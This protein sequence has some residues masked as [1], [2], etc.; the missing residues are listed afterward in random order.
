MINILKR[1]WLEIDLSKL[2]KNLEIL[3]SLLLPENKHQIACVIKANAY[4]HDDKSIACHLEK[5]GVVFFAVSNIKEAIN[6]RKYGIKGEILILGYTPSEY[7]DVL[8][9]NN[10]IQTIVSES[11][12]IS[13]AECAQKKGIRVKVHVAL[14]TGMGR[15]GLDVI[16]EN[17]CEKVAKVLLN[18]SRMKGIE[19]DGLFTHYAVADSEDISDIE[20]T[21]KQTRLFLDVCNKV[22]KYGVLL[23]HTHCLNSAGGIYH[24]S[25]YSTLVRFGILLYGLKP[26]RN[27]IIPDGIEPIM[28]FKSVVSCVKQHKKGEFIGYGRK[29]CCERNMSVATIPVGYADGYM[30]VLS[31]KANVLVNGMRTQIVGNICMDQLM[32]DVTT[33]TNVKEGDIVTLIGRDGTECI[34]ADEL[35]EQSNTINYEIVCGISKRVPR[36]IYEKGKIVDIIEYY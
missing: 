15:I 2:E 35:A 30:R 29:Y 7:V 21:D 6:L 22:K 33:I 3:S 1:A 27:L 17:N 32:I 8:V 34:Y 4:G 16:E 18:I 12:A 14:D 19:L 28:E 36:V 26:N 11:H 23:R 9:E 24:Y 25:N 13:I 20:Y 10:I 31:S 5:L